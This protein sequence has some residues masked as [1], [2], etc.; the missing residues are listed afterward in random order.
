MPEQPKLTKEKD[1]SS[2]FNAKG[3][4]ISKSVIGGGD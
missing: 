4:I 2:N 1:S 3:G